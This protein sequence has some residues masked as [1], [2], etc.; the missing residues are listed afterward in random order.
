MKKFLRIFSVPLL[1]FSLLASSLYFT[2]NA[3][4]QTVLTLL[5]SEAQ[6]AGAGTGNSGL[7]FIEIYNPTGSSVDISGW[8]LKKRTKTGSESSINVFDSGAIIPAYG[9]FL[10]ANSKDGFAD[11]IYADEKS[12]ASIAA[13]NSIAF[14]DNDGNLIDAVA[15][16]VDLED[17]FHEGIFLSVELEANQSFERKTWDNGC[18][19]AEGERETDGNGCDTDDNSYDFELRKNSN[20]QNSGSKKEPQRNQ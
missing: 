11:L 10:W 3:R 8:R 6:I 16:G 15:W 1:L 9:F 4:S 12:T 5:I 17:A 20:P 19:K 13:N 18:F 2:K 14:I 7:D